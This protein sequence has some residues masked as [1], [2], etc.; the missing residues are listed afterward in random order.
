MPKPAAL[1]KDQAVDIGRV[2]KSSCRFQGFDAFLAR[3]HVPR[4]L[5]GLIRVS[6]EIM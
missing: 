3:R 4:G 6:F 5:K 2:S 1:S